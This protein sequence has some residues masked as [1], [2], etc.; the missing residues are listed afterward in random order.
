MKTDQF[1]GETFTEGI[2]LAILIILLIFGSTDIK[3]ITDAPD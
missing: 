3:D 1:E 2:V